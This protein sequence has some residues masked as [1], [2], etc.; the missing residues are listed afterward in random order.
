MR[1]ETDFPWEVRRATSWN[2]YSNVLGP[3]GRT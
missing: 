3:A 1:T 2:I